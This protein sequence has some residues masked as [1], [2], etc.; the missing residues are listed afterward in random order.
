MRYYP[1]VIL[2]IA[3]L[4]ACG[5]TDREP[6]APQTIVPLYRS[7]AD[8]GK[9]D[10]VARDSFMTVDSA[11]I[12]AMVQVL[13][14]DTVTAAELSAW[15][16]SMPVTIF[17]P[18]TD[19]VFPTLRPLEDTL[20]AILAASGREGLELPV[21]S[22]AAVIWGNRRSIVFNGDVMLIAL[23]HYLGS[24]YPGYEHWPLYMRIDKTP[25][26]LPYDIA[27]ALV[28][29]SYPYR[30]GDGATALS[31]MIYEGALATAKMR[32]VPDARLT[33]VLGYNEKEVEW[34]DEH[35]GELWSTLASR[36]L[37]YDTS[38]AT[39]DKLVA[40]APTTAIISA[41]V[42][43]RAGRYI[44]YR[45]VSEYLKKNPQT[46]LSHMLSPEFY[47]DAAVLVESGYDGR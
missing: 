8:F 32:L 15:S 19:S 40:P 35:Q 34:L 11:Q 4:A 43:R 3:V 6:S 47:T 22:Y 27:E 44:G 39:A 28:A 18:P 10:S 21:R 46:T 31:R 24:D 23:N 45:I 36:D 7:M 1:F 37:L 16:R 5:R 30:G 9:M 17:T 13:G 29:D 26:R 33:E 2:L 12:I 14:G 42:P 20:G 25:Q 41:Y 38:E